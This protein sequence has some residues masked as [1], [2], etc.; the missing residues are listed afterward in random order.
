MSWRSSEGTHDALS[1]KKYSFLLLND[2]KQSPEWHCME[3]EIGGRDSAVAA[4]LTAVASLAY[5]CRFHSSL[6]DSLAA[7]V[8]SFWSLH[9]LSSLCTQVEQ[10]SRGSRTGVCTQ[11]EH[12][13]YTDQHA[14]ISLPVTRRDRVTVYWWEGVK[15]SAGWMA[16]GRHKTNIYKSLHL[17]A[18][19]YS[20][21]GL[22]LLNILHQF[23]HT[24]FG[25]P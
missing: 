21:V 7:P 6:I 15:Y 12:I 11:H 17:N 13:C 3:A 18:G 22:L 1:N 20:A 19:H 4:A 5:M 24:V 25:H 9:P 16:V 23:S 14:S 10:G 2:K 8:S